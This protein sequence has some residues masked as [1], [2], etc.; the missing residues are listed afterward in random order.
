MSPG[1]P[2]WDVPADYDWAIHAA[3]RTKPGL[4]WTENVRFVDDH[5]IRQMRAVC[6]SCP[7]FAACERFVARAGV[8][9]GYWAGRGRYLYGDA[10]YVRQPRRKRAA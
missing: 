7:V 8:T 6:S 9:A 4:P 5:K 1:V 10:D 3:C 2:Q